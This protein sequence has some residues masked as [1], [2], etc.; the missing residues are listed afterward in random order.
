[1]VID[2]D[3]GKITDSQKQL[4]NQA[5]NSSERMVNLINDFLNVSRIQTGKFIIEKNEINL[6]V[7]IDQEIENLQPSADARNVTFKYIKPDDFPKI[8]VDEGKIRQVIMNFLDNSVYYSP[9][10]STV[11]INLKVQKDEVIFTVKDKGIGVPLREKSQLFTK[12]YRASNAKQK[13][14]DGTGVGLYLAK[15]IIDAQGGSVIFESVEGKGST[16]GFKLPLK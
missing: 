9:D 11:N 5:F 8:V 4:L 1:M 14:P 15:K 6:A 3:A 10:G 7:V 2:G 13:R 16:F 12:F